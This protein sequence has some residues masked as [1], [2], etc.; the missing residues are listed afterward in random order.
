MRMKRYEI[1]Y[2]YLYN[3]IDSLFSIIQINFS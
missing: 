2:F 3:Q 1:D